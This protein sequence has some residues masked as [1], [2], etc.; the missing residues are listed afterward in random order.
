MQYR[1]ALINF[2][3]W[4][5]YDDI[6]VDPYKLTNNTY[7]SIIKD[8]DAALTENPNIDSIIGLMLCDGFLYKNTPKFYN[9]LGRVQDYCYNKGI[10]KLYLIPGICNQVQDILVSKGLH[11]EILDWD[12]SIN[13]MYQ[14]YK[15][16]LS[17]LPNWNP[18]SEK[19]LFLGGIPSRVNRIKLLSKFYDAN[20]LENAEWSFFK[21]ITA[22]DA[23]VCRS[24]MQHYSDYEYD[25]F[26]RVCERS[27]DNLYKDSI[28][29]S[30]ISGKQ[31]LDDPTILNKPFL[32]D[33]NYIDPSVFRNTA[34]SIISEGGI[35]ALGAGIDGTPFNSK[36][37][38]EKTWRTIVNRHPFILADT[39]ERF[40][41]VK[42]L[43]LRT[44]E[45]YMQ[46]PNYA[47]ISDDDERLDAIVT[48]TQYFLNTYQ[49]RQHE[50]AQDIEYN[51]QLFFKLASKNYMLTHALN[52]DHNISSSDIVRWFEQKSFIHLLR[53]P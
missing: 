35:D 53:M 40:E 25:E 6:S 5:T 29:Y 42:S 20:M 18:A 19:F 28:S 36:F 41:F 30:R 37:L 49:H 22:E 38:T 52:K 34:I 43:G 9:M 2:E 4:Y 12:F 39:P 7:D 17:Q 46:I 16:R 51:F 3:L 27:I 32:Q 8:I 23:T 24:I 26:L 50:I 48:N 13:A 10:T 1:S 15:G 44:F 14:S 45:N 21:P 11:Y 33:P 31:W 47:Y